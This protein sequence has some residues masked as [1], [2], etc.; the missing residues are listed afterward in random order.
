MAEKS[1]KIVKALLGDKADKLT[2]KMDAVNDIL[3][4]KQAQELK[5]KI[6]SAAIQK[7]FED[8]DTAQLQAFIKAV[9]NTKEGQELAKKFGGIL[10]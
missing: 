6:D 2:G 7:A 8:G 10:D 5:N 9:V 1:E 3:N 4:S